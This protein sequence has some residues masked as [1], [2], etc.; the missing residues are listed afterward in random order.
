MIHGNKRQGMVFAA[1]CGLN[2][3]L[4]LL[5][6][7]P[8]V[9][10]VPIAEELGVGRGSVAMTLTVSNLAFALGGLL[11]SRL[12]KGMGLRRLVAAGTAV[13]VAATVA[14]S[15]AQSLLPLYLLNALRGLAVGAIGLVLMTIV[16]NN[17]FQRN[18]SLV[19]SIVLSCSGITGIVLSP[20]LSFLIGK[21]NWRVGILLRLS[22]HGL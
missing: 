5:T 17:W 20:T 15:R 2:A 21:T 7:V 22:R 18:N 6:N 8:G 13:N 3:S 19:A 1:M 16:L 4:G 11:S 14:L 12:M 9:F 10:F